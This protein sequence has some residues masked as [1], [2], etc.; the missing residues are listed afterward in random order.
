MTYDVILHLRHDFR[1][2]KNIFGVVFSPRTT[3]SAQGA[4]ESDDSTENIPVTH[5][6]PVE[7]IKTNKVGS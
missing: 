5:I 3:C 2:R 4:A 6:S 1:T 7:A